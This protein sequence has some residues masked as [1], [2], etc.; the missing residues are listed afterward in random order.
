MTTLISPSQLLALK[1]RRSN[2]SAQNLKKQNKEKD[3]L[4]KRV[5]AQLVKI[6]TRFPKYQTE[7][8][9]H[10]TRKWSLDYAWPGHKVALEVHGGTYASGRHTQGKGF[11]LDREKMNEAQ[12]LGWI[13]I[14]VTTD[15]IERISEWIERALLITSVNVS[16]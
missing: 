11:A 9:F 16:K 7:H 6:P 15:N 13:V 5:R 2:K 12:L 8:K 1:Q 14:E 4:H 3:E 10:E